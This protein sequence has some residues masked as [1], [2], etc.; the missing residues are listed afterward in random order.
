MEKVRELWLWMDPERRSGPEAMAVDEWLLETVENPVLRVYGWAGD[1]ASLGYFGQIEPARAAIP[2]VNWV[3]RWT[4]G[5][6]VDH[7]SDWTYSL[8]LPRSEPL[9]QARGAGSYRAIHDGLRQALAVEGVDGQLSAGEDE[10]GDV[11]CFQ[12]PVC[13]DLIGKGAGKLAGA[14]QRRSRSGL[15]HQGSV[16]VACDAAGSRARAARLCAALSA[17]WHETGFQ[18]D[19]DWVASLVQRRYGNRQ[20]QSRR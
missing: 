7:R 15:L 6:M 13:H 14:G 4:G 17:G 1:W 20:W 3:R 18:P 10:T 8:I 5:G 11:L 2:A 16:A 9:A 19:R 12:N